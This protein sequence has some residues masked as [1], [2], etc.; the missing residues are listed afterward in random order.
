MEITPEERR[1]LPLLATPLSFAEI[2]EI[3]EI[4]R[5]AVKAQA[6]GVYAK[7]DV[8]PQRRGRRDV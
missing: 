6:V 3:L 7:L 2:A 5:D 8:R 1:L 4:P